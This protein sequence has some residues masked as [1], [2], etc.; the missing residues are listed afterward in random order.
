VARKSLY[1]LKISKLFCHDII[2]HFFISDFERPGR[3]K[4]KFRSR[5]WFDEEVVEVG[6]AESEGHLPN[7]SWMNIHFVLFSI[8]INVN[9][10]PRNKLHMYYYYCTRLRYRGSKME[11][12]PTRPRSQCSFSIFLVVLE[13]AQYSRL[14]FPLLRVILVCLH[15][16]RKKR[17]EPLSCVR[18]GHR[19]H[20][21]DA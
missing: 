9:G 14:Y 21:H 16:G 19:Y 12:L 8:I 11:Q 18:I 3:I 20:H 5:E 13:A 10:L 4:T 2:L 15:I 7:Q 1:R 6:L 17:N